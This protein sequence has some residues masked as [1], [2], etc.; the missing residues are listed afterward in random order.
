MFKLSP[1]HP[2]NSL[3]FKTIFSAT[4]GP[5][6]GRLRCDYK[7]RQHKKPQN[8]AK[9]LGFHFSKFVS[10]RKKEL[11]AGKT[12]FFKSLKLRVHV[13][14]FYRQL[15]IREAAVMDKRN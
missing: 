2:K 13:L 14:N 15:V 10:F 11:A 6:Y 3:S 12:G 4:G 7:R 5:G 1:T 9:N 8:E